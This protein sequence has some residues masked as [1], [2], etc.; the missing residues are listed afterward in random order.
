M[1]TIE[2]DNA[3]HT[4]DLTA[5][6]LKSVELRLRGERIQKMT[7]ALYAGNLFHAAVRLWHEDPMLEI[8]VCVM[9]AAKMVEEQSRS[10]GRPLTDAVIADRPEHSGKCEQWLRTYAAAFSAMFPKSVVWCE[11]P[12]R[13]TLTID[14]IDEDFAS[15]LDGLVVPIDSPT[16]MTIIDWKTG[17][18]SPTYEYLSRNLQLGLYWLMVRKGR[19]MMDGK[20]CRPISNPRVAWIHA[21]NLQPYGKRGEYVGPGGE[22]IQYKKGDLRP[23]HKIIQFVNFDNEDALLAELTTRVRMK[24]AGLYPTNPD[25]A[26]CFVCESNQYCPK[27][28]KGTDENQ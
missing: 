26:G 20:W 15:H 1:T 23:L 4:S 13:I 21:R 16:D 24:R 19:V 25:P 11:V 18:D 28:T 3:T 9:T 6:C 14:G 12:V 27:F 2:T 17:E 22:V 8:P 7:T 5:A 10:E